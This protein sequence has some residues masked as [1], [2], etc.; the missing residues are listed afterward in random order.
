MEW[1]AAR[2]VQRYLYQRTGILVPVS[3]N[4]VPEGRPN[5]ILV[6]NRQRDLVDAYRIT[7]GIND[8]GPEQYIL[9]TIAGQQGRTVCLIGGDDVGTLYAAYR[10]AEVLGVRFYLHG[11]V[12]PDERMALQLPEVDEIGKPLFSP[13]G[14]QPF[15]DFPEG[16]DWWSL[17][18]Y[19]AILAQL[20]K[21]R[22]NFLALHTYPEDRPNAEPTTW[23]GLKDDILPDG[24]VRFSYP[25][26]YQNTLRGNWGYL[27][28]YTGDFLFGASDL[29][30]VDGYGNDVMTGL[31][32]Q[33][34]EPERCN[35]TFNRAGA[36]FD[37]AFTY[38]RAL[39]VKTCIGTETPLTIPTRVRERLQ[40]RGKDPDSPEVRQ[41]LYEG[42]FQRI[43]KTHPLDYYWFWT[44]EGWTWGGNKPEETQATLDDINAAIAA[45]HAVNA[46]FNLA[47]CGWVL[48]PENDRA[49]FDER[50]PKD[51]AMSCINRQVG[52][53]PVEEGFQRVKGRPIWAIP[54][55][56]D[57]PALTA[58]Q[59]WA[60]RMR[61]DAVDAY[62][63]GCTGLL[64]IHWR[65][66][67]LGPNVSAL[68]QAAWEQGAWAKPRTITTPP[69]VDGPLDG[70][71]TAYPNDL[72]VKG[73]DDPTVYRTVRWGLTGYRLQVPNGLYAV[74]LRFCE[75][76]YKETGQRV[77]DVKLQNKT[78]LER[79]DLVDRVGLACAL[80]CTF[81]GIMVTDGTLAID[82]VAHAAESLIAA[83]EITGRDFTRAINCGGLAYEHY[84]T[85][86]EPPK[87]PSRDLPTLDFYRDWARALFG[88]RGAE[89]IG[90]YFAKLDGKL[91]RPCD[92]KN[93]PGGINP[94]ARPWAEVAKEYEFVDEMARLRG[95]VKGAGN[96]E[97]FDYWLDNFKYMRAVA[98]LKCVWH[99][100]IE[101][102]KA[103][104]A[105]QDRDERARYARKHALPRLE[106]M[107]ERVEEIYEYLLN[108][109]SNTGEMGT[110]ANWDQSIVPEVIHL[111]QRALI[112]AMGEA[113]PEEAQT[114][115]EYEGRPRIVVPTLRGMLTAGETLVLKV[116][117]LDEGETKHADLYWRIM[118]QG[119]FQRVPL[120]HVA[121]G[122][123]QVQL[124]QAADAETFEYYVEVQPGKGRRVYFPA[125]APAMNQT[126]V[127]MP[128]ME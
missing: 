3:E 42:M 75:D 58:P 25:S 97:R 103:A 27:T 61:A 65:T 60:G 118:G 10:F 50:L 93:G 121:R 99:R 68:A 33:P 105:I 85:D 14:I 107:T 32:P 128:K 123:Y 115:Q 1:L 22:M 88:A 21:L 78:V 113:L 43:L 55:M 51:I 18:D 12:I 126:V 11:D 80:D 108:T 82:F 95:R 31:C 77:F 87:T 112:E 79:L 4:G 57:D 117:V 37:E 13:R 102:M 24:K 44:P 76:H 116:I 100:F 34:V 124:P 52:F 41:E 98:E 38:A 91:P 53:A 35:E 28:K 122:V 23:I 62:K 84:S 120:S 29:F 110:I 7:L 46:P 81:D 19:K 9:K 67:I 89:E 125:T 26:S 72:D 114:E 17:D 106:E 70:S 111:T 64:G 36:V 15:H 48:G 109:V 71:K 104:E 47:T 54:W 39:G 59:L 92:W 2:E 20:P 56:E 74:T 127:V 119:Q 94:D 30:E 73:T 96:L 63:Y 49:F 16:P 66:R 101:A 8:L 86:P 40:A 6:A 83:I 45:R 90:V 5:T 69:V